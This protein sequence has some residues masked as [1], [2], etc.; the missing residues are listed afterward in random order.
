MGAALDCGG[1]LTALRRTRIAD[2]DVN[3]A[4]GLEDLEK[5]GPAVAASR[6]LPV[7][8]L[9]SAY[10]ALRLDSSEAKRVGTGLEV[11]PAVALVAQGSVRLYGPTGTFLG[12]G[13]VRTDGIVAPKR[14]LASP[15][16]DRQ[17]HDQPPRT[18]WK[19]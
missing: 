19:P 10:P 5:A 6:M 8:L 13:E 2:L 18:A 11:R 15:G 16:A 7:D 9:V 4:I 14:M 12:V 1:Y 17:P 3:A